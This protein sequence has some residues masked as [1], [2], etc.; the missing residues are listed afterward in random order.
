MSEA[1]VVLPLVTRVARN[2]GLE[3]DAALLAATAAIIAEGNAVTRHAATASVPGDPLDLMRA[4]AALQGPVAQAIRSAAAGTLTAIQLVAHN[5]GEALRQQIGAA[6]IGALAPSQVD[7]RP[8]VF[9]VAS[10]RLKLTYDV[11]LTSPASL[12]VTIHLTTLDGTAQADRGDY[13]PAIGTLTFAPGETTK[14]L[15]VDLLAAQ[16]GDTVRVRLTDVEHALLG[17]SR[18]V[19]TGGYRTVRRRTG[20]GCAGPTADLCL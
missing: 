2:S 12:P 7:I 9:T 20:I 4:A 13:A 6:A 11:V 1:G 10:N 19:R 8:G 16:P 5:T 14:S 18:S 17:P 15:T 3:P